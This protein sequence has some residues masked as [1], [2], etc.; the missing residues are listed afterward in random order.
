ME[1][2]GNLTLCFLIINMNANKRKEKEEEEEDYLCIIF[3][4]G[5]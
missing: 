1:Y 3:N 2:S 5:S 4:E